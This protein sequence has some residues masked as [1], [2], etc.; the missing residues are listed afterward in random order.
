MNSIRRGEILRCARDTASEHGFHQLPVSPK[1]IAEKRDIMV[2][3]WDSPTLGISGCLMKMGDQFS[4]GYSTA[5][6]NSGFENFTIAHELGHYFLDGHPEA[7]L[8][9]GMHVSKSGYVSQDVHEKEADLFASEL[10]MP[11]ALFRDAIRRGGS[12]FPFIRRLAELAETSIVATAIRYAK[13]SDDPVAVILSEGPNINW[14]F[15]SAALEECP[16][17]YRLPKSSLLPSGS[18]TALFNRD[19]ENVAKAQGVEGMSTLQTWFERASNAE[20]KEDVVGL[21]HYARTLTVLFTEEV[22]H[23]E[24]IDGDD[25]NEGLDTELPSARWASR[26]RNRY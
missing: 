13:L 6:K 12:G 22:L 8:A 15:L 3:P 16:G 23:S 7:L 18:A 25:S 4:I 9:N 24:E 21:G 20:M 10:L 1:I 5:I 19:L 17:V 11:E 2:M 26:D 14:C